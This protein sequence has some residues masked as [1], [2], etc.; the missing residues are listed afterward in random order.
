M[1]TTSPFLGTES[2]L[3]RRVL[4]SR[5]QRLYRNVYLPAGAPLTPV[6][7][8]VGAWLWSGRAATV[9]GLSASA[10]HGVRWVDAQ[11]PAEL[12]RTQ[13][14]AVDGIVIHR[15]TLVADEVCVVR[16][17]PVT[18]PERTSFDLG[19]WRPLID[20]VVRVDALAHV[21]RLTA[22]HI[23]PLVQRHRGA[24]GLARLRTVLALMDGGAESPQET[25]TRLLLLAAG[26]PRPRTQI[27]V[28][29]DH[30]YF[31][32]RLDMGW[33][34]WKV[35]IEYDGPQHWTDPAVRARDIDRSAELQ[36]QGWTIIRVSRDI[37]KYRPE[38]FLTRVRDA[39][40]RGGWLDYERI[41]LDAGLE[42]WSG[43]P[44]LD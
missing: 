4:R 44:V 24:R 1:G 32:G 26:F 10:L 43:H 3:S 27:L 42:S 5:H 16:G 34:R 28:C 38:V 41:R 15:E 8:A 22:A 14:G 6:V 11:A 12:I 36:Q 23:E 21:T 30:G 29:D 39:M 13:A 33:R 9:A 31:I 19:R 25:R 17:I 20:A 35:G 2:E 18:T 40:R 7:R 37:M